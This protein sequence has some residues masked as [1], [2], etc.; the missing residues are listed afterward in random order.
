ME[1]PKPR[2]GPKPARWPKPRGGPKPWCTST[3][4]A[5]LGLDWACLA[6]YE[7]VKQEIEDALAPSVLL[8]VDEVDALAPSRDSVRGVHEASTRV[9]SI[10]L[11]HIDGFESEG[12][13]APAAGGSGG[14]VLVGATNRR[15]DID[16]ALL[17]R[18]D[19]VVHFGLPDAAARAAIFAAYARQLPE[20]DLAALAAASEG[21]AGRDIRDA[22][23]AAERA[24]AGRLIRRAAA[25]GAGPPRPRPLP[26]LQDYLEAVSRR[27]TGRGGGRGGGS[28][29]GSGADDAGRRA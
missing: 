26:A 7:S 15:G 28:G 3:P 13:A 17:S 2:E 5:S 29:G 24:F 4:A 23:V 21:L 19:L 1:W 11:R 22:C 18:F 27:R 20:G 8:F 6:G 9:M 12:G 25:E 10:L 16:A 14:V